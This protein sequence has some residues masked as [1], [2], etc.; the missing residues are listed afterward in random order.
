MVVLFGEKL[1]L[2]HTNERTGLEK[3]LAS[4]LGKRTAEKVLS[5]AYY[6]C[7]GDALSSCQSWLGERGLRELEASGVSELLPALTE[8]K[9]SGFFKVW[10]RKRAKDRNGNEEVRI[11]GRCSSLPGQELL[12]EIGL[13]LFIM[14]IDVISGRKKPWAEQ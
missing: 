5:L 4:S 10:V 11:I 3:A 6:I 9:C 12:E 7:T 14:I 13:K 1:A 8:G 2:S